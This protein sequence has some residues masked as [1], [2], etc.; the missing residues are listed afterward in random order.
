MNTVKKLYIFSSLIFLLK[1]QHTLAEDND[2]FELSLDDLLNISTSVIKK[3]KLRVN[4]LQRI[5]LKNN[6]VI[7]AKVELVSVNLIGKPVRMPLK[8]FDLF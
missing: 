4:L 6:I 3:S 1:S 8:L 7:E 5:F 2:L